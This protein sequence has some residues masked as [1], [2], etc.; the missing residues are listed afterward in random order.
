M[1]PEIIHSSNLQKPIDANTSNEK[2]SMCF[3]QEN[4]GFKSLCENVCNLGI[5]SNHYHFFR[6]NGKTTYRSKLGIFLTMMF[7]LILAL[8]IIY[9]SYICFRPLEPSVVASKYYKNLTVDDSSDLLRVV[10]PIVYFRYF[11]NEDMR[12]STVIDINELQC[13]FDFQFYKATDSFRNQKNLESIGCS[14]NCKNMYNKIIY[15]NKVEGGK[16]Y[17][18][19]DDE[20]LTSLDNALCVSTDS[21]EVYG[22]HENCNGNCQYFA[23]SLK[24]KPE[25]ERS[26]CTTNFDYEKI[27]VT[28]LNVKSYI[29]PTDYDNPRNFY[30]NYKKVFLNTKQNKIVIQHYGESKLVTKSYNFFK[31]SEESKNSIETNKI[32]EEAFY[33]QQNLSDNTYKPV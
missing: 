7:Y 2:I 30:G 14:N 22:N 28:I 24:I 17:N 10:K 5:F 8:S 33:K 1:N 4:S 9:Y 19:F 18:N 32:S 11:S 13:H 21:M 25:S 12:E 3:T 15:E 6:Y 31:L 27:L 16:F 29:N 20:F 23:F 26:T